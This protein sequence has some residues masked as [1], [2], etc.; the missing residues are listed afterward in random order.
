MSWIGNDDNYLGV[1][2]CFCVLVVKIEATKT[3]NHKMLPDVKA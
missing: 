2:W 3:P 1:F